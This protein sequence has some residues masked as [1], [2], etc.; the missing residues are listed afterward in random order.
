MTRNEGAARSSTP[1]PC[2]DGEHHERS[3]GTGGEAGGPRALPSWRFQAL[4]TLFSESFSSFPHGTC[5]L[6]VSRPCLALG[7]V[8]HPLGAAFPNS[9]TLGARATR[10]RTAGT[11]G[12]PHG[13][14]TLRGTPFQGI[15]PRPGGAPRRQATRL[16][17][18]ARTCAHPD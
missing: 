4:L 13:A 7:G 2:L 11:P 9:P 15:S 10:R 12:L 1:R 5:S 8:Y 17:F 16:Q 3:S 18:G 14:L 6:S